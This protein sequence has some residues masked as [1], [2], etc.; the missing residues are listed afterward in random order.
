MPPTDA[1]H[2]TALIGHTGFVGSNIAR[3]RLTDDVYNSTNIDD[4]AGR[5]YDLVISAAG[6]ADS[7]RINDEPEQDRAE[8]EAFARILSRATIRRLVHVSTVCVYGPEDEVDESVSSDPEDLTPYGRN[9]LWLERA[10]ADR[11]DT[12][13][14][15]LPQL[16]GP[17]IKKG[18]VFDLANDHRVEFIRPDGVFQ[19]YD[20]TRMSDDIDVALAC[21]LSVLNV[22]TEPVVHRDLAR[23][24]FGVEL[25]EPGPAHESPFAAMYTSNMLTRH[26]DV[27]GRQGRYLMTAAEEMASIDR[28]V[29]H[30]AAASGVEV[31]R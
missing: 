27:F 11:F 22:A 28:F 19:Y 7:H 8:L 16:F 15:R 12:L 6:R 30:D 25:A 5:E 18:L 26:A 24:V 2:R 29:H 21:G 9:R 31:G 10:L 3:D 20:L 4:I 23:E 17:G 1:P 14:M 13:T